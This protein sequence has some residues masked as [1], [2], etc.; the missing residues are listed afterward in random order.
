M[1]CASVQNYILTFITSGLVPFSLLT[2][3]WTKFLISRAQRFL[4][5]MMYRLLFGLFLVTLVENC[6]RTVEARPVKMTAHRLLKSSL[7]DGKA[8]RYY[9]MHLI[10]RPKAE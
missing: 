5:P 3:L 2:F 6:P 4:A 1:W 10:S 9:P 7:S 8:S